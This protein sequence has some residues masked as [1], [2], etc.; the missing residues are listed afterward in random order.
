M[1]LVDLQSLSVADS[2]GTVIKIKVR[3][4]R[5]GDLKGGGI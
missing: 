4:V 1:G 3:H 5:R 2:E